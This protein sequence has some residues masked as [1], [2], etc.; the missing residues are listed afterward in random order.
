[1]AVTTATKKKRPLR[2]IV[3]SILNSRKDQSGGF[4]GLVE[5]DICLPNVIFVPNF[6]FPLRV[7]LRN[8]QCPAET[9]QGYIDVERSTTTDLF[10]YIDTQWAHCS[11]PGP[12]TPK[13]CFRLRFE[14]TREILKI[15]LFEKLPLNE[16]GKSRP[17]AESNF[18]L[19]DICEN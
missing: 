18:T 11:F 16:T 15:G 5:V 13:R 4:F 6:S 3:N 2:Y 14:T 19:I 9:A 10:P 8:Y 7:Q 1:M 17:F 12:I